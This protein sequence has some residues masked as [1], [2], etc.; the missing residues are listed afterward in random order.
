ML[1]R[2]LSFNYVYAR[3]Q[4]LDKAEGGH[5]TNDKISWD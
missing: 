5:S 3:D 1:V 4:T 2:V